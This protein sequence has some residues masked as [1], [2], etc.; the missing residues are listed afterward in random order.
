MPLVTVIVKDGQRRPVSNALIAV[1]SGTVPSA[2]IAFLTDSEGCFAIRLHRGHYVLGAHSEQSGNGVIECELE[3]S[4][5]N[6][7][8]QLST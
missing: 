8:I 5:I 7:I 1:E 2:D 6:L 3:D 4:D